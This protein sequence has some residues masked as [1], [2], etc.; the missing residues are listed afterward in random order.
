MHLCPLLGR[1]VA[2][3]SRGG[4]SSGWRGC[5]LSNCPEW[6]DLAVMQ[7]ALLDP[8][9]PEWVAQVVVVIPGLIP[10]HL[11]LLRPHIASLLADDQ[12]A[13]FLS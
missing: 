13:A 12:S 4:V 3:Y 1:G 5:L 10:G 7:P 2:G 9:R 6:T 8:P 11:P